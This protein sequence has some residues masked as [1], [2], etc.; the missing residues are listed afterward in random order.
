MAEKVSFKISTDGIEGPTHRTELT[1]RQRAEE[2]EVPAD[3][4]TENDPLDELKDK[5]I[6]DKAESTRIEK[7]KVD[8]V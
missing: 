3:P 2:N 5:A 7:G 4:D 1:L 8:K 6:K